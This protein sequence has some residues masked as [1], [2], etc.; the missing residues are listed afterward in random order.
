MRQSEVE[1][2]HSWL[3]EHVVQGVT[4]AFQHSHLFAYAKHLQPQ[5]MYKQ[6]V[7]R[8]YAGRRYFTVQ[9]LHVSLPVWGVSVLVLVVCLGL[10][11]SANPGLPVN[12]SCLPFN[13][14]LQLHLARHHLPASLFYSAYWHS[15][16]GVA[17]LLLINAILAAIHW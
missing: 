16:A 5:S 13:H 11:L 8:S 4:A 6:C 17:T 15:T 2:A 10:H 14:R 7:R 12:K 1:A 9:S 3:P